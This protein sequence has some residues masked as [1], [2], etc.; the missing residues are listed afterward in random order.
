[1]KNYNYHLINL[2]LIATSVVVVAHANDVK[3]YR[4]NRKQ[5][6]KNILLEHSKEASTNC[7]HSWIGDKSCDKA[8]DNKEN[9]FD[10]GDCLPH[11]Q[12]VHST[13]KVEQ[14]AGFD[15][16]VIGFTTSESTREEH[17]VYDVP[18][19]TVRRLQKFQ[20]RPR[21]NN[22]KFKIVMM[23]VSTDYEKAQ[24][25]VHQDGQGNLFVDAIPAN[26]AVGINEV[27][28]VTSNND[29][30]D[31][32]QIVVLFNPWAV[33]SP[34]HMKPY[35]GTDYLEEFIL[36]LTGQS[37]YGD[38]SSGVESI[39]TKR[40]FFGTKTWGYH[41]DDVAVQE[42][43][44]KLLNVLGSLDR[45]DPRK[46]S[47]HFTKVLSATWN[48]NG[49]QGMLS[50]RWD[51]KYGDGAKPTS[52]TGS[53][54]IYRQYLNNGMRSS[55]KYGQ[56]WVFGGILTTA[57]RYLGIPSRIVVNFRSAHLIH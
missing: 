20:L 52:W 34:V 47:R 28:F 51:G 18:F 26:V 5:T 19:T 8:C 54:D 27:L 29:K 12:Q 38:A 6:V 36:E 53:R 16:Q 11:F 45:K 1:M 30:I 49:Y 4:E 33:T 14:Q 39:G 3:T 56:C 43:V 24:L 21:D 44:L 48:G 40:N 46:V 55:V 35:K 32:G 15:V 10:G 22:P 41:H 23:Q 37:Y 2:L 7:Y 17:H 42:V 57:L 9:N 25:K 31:G 50:G 13:E